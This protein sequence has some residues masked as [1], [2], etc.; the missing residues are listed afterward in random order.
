VH[1]ARGEYERCKE[2][3]NAAV[4]ICK[5]VVPPSPQADLA[6]RQSLAYRQ[7]LARALQ[8]L[9]Y[10]PMT[11]AEEYKALVEQW[12]Q[13][14]G[15]ELDLAIVKR[16]YGECLRT[17]GGVE[18]E[19]AGDDVLAEAAELAS[20]FREHPVRAE[21]F[22]SQWRLAGQRGRA[23]ANALRY[24]CVEAARESGHEM[25]LAIVDHQEFWRHGP[26]TCQDWPA[27]AKEWTK[28][29]AR[30]E[31]YPNH[32]W[33]LRSAIDGRL[34]EAQFQIENGELEVAF[35]TLLRNAAS[36]KEHPGFNRGSDQYRIARTW[37]GLQ[38]IADQLHKRAS[39]WEDL[40]LHP[41]ASAWLADRGLSSSEKAWQW[42]E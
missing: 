3:L 28:I 17:L 25:L 20:R 38:W 30:L 15:A 39:Y 4:G 26:K 2:A 13:L 35:R 11:A 34:R 7:D 1:K 33:A 31:S 14:D 23:N 16:N 10:R 9:D 32:G 27:V 12:S 24:A 19:Q 8:Y 36:L 37:A 29:E 41:W 42:R 5:S 22:Y 21:V 18:N 6:L 40:N